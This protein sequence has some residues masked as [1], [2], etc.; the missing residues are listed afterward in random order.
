MFNMLA[1]AKLGLLCALYGMNIWYFCEACMS[2]TYPQRK[3]G[4]IEHQTT[5]INDAFQFLSWTTTCICTPYNMWSL[6]CNVVFC[7]CGHL[8]FLFLVLYHSTSPLRRSAIGAIFVGMVY[9][10]RSWNVW[11][12]ASCSSSPILTVYNQSLASIGTR[13]SHMEEGLVPIPV[14]DWLCT[15]LDYSNRMH[16]LHNYFLLHFRASSFKTDHLHEIMCA[17]KFVPT[18]CLVCHCCI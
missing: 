2:P 1:S 10:T 5:Y 6:Y 3:L 17:Q 16:I 14:S 12:F 15:V 8:L 18:K 13:P 9:W 11:L 4:A 7:A